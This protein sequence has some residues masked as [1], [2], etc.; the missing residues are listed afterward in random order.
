MFRELT[1]L[2]NVSGSPLIGNLGETLNGLTTIRTFRKQEDFIKR[3][4]EILDTKLSISFWKESL[5]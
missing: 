3:N 4:L 5:K 1:R 2:E